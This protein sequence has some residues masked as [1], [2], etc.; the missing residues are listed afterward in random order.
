MVDPRKT[1]PSDIEREL[2]A[3]FNPGNVER[4]S[5]TAQKASGAEYVEALALP[6]D[7]RGRMPFTRDAFII[8][9]NPAR[10]EW[11]RQT[12]KFLN[13]LNS[14]FG[15]RVTAPMIYEWTTGISL[16]ELVKAE[17]VDPDKW[18]GG[19]SWG[20]ANMHLRHI[21][22]LLVE[23]FGKPYKTTIMGR[24]VGKAYTVKPGFRI[25]NKK[26]ICLTLWPEWEDGVL[27]P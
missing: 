7:S 22:A 19:A 9:E 26:P 20:S 8:N 5:S 21:N 16:A 2:Q 25:K 10:V 27:N 3:R 6:E 18:Q 1:T 13:K 14:D 23:Y 17:G 4:F 12:R 24:A 15:H 11:E